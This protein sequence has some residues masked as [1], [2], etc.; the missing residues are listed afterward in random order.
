MVHGASVSE[1]AVEF[2]GAN[3]ITDIDGA[4][5]LM[6]GQTADF[7]HKRMGYWERTI[8]SPWTCTRN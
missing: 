4:C 1:A 6:F 7:G 5:P 3:D 8:L 2:C